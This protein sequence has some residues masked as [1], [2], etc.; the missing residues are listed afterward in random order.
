[1]RT[2]SPH[3]GD[4][5]DVVELLEASHLG[6]EGEKIMDEAKICAT[7]SL[8]SI[9]KDQLSN[10]V[11]VERMVHSLELPSHWR[12]QWFEVKWHIKQYN[13]EKN[14]DPILLEMSKLNFNMIQATLQLELKELSRY[15]YF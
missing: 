13:K 4:V 1:M 2:I 10:N 12:V 7:N 5:K 3:V 6:L 11:D 14:M 15:I 8:N 9:K